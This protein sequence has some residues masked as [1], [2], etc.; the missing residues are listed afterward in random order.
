VAPRGQEDA[1][2]LGICSSPEDGLM[3]SLMTM[4]GEDKPARPKAVRRLAAKR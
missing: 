2:L 1:L 3:E 4:H